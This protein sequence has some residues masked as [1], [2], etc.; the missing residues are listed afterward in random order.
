MLRM[1]AALTGIGCSVLGGVSTGVLLAAT[2]RGEGIRAR[3]ALRAHGRTA[4][5]SAACLTLVFSVGVLAGVLSVEY[6][7]VW[8]GLTCLAAMLL[9]TVA[10]WLVLIETDDDDEPGEVPDDPAWW[11]EFECELREWA[12]NRVPA[13]RS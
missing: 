3:A 2:T 11:P 5:W 10:T 9:L 6:N 13:G 1:V 8:L 12:R 7:R 4:T